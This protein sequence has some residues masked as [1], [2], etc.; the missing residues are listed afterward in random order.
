VHFIDSFFWINCKSGVN[1]DAVTN[2]SLR[3]YWQ[4]NLFF[5]KN[6]FLFSFFR[7]RSKWDQPA[8]PFASGTVPL[9]ING[10][11]GI[12]LP[13][14]IPVVNSSLINPVQATLNLPQVNSVCQMFFFLLL[15]SKFCF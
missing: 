10:T 15:S 7:K 12:S 13:G 3:S 4:N 8:E 5:V 6:I 9:T 11:V 14:L 2:Y 1:N